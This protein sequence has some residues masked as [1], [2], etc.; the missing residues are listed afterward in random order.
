VT[1]AKWFYTFSK[2]GDVLTYA[3]TGGQKMPS[4]DGFGD[5]NLPWAT[6][7]AGGAVSATR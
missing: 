7:Q 2:I 5:W 1:D 6:W 3:N 4:W